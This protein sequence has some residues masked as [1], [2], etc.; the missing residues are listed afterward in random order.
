MFDGVKPSLFDWAP[1]CGV[2]I[3]DQSRSVRE[4]KCLDL[5]MGSN[6]LWLCAWLCVVTVVEWHWEDIGTAVG[7]HGEDNGWCRGPAAWGCQRG[8][9]LLGHN[10]YLPQLWP[11]SF[12]GAVENFVSLVI[13]YFELVFVDVRCAISI[14]EFTQAEYVVGESRDDVSC[15]C[16]EQWGAGDCQDCRPC[17][18]FGFPGGCLDSHFWCCGVNIEQWCSRHEVVVTC[19]SVYYCCGITV[20]CGWGG[21]ATGY[22]GSC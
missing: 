5:A 16:A 3:C 20:V 6:A 19:P 11:C 7:W 12:L 10:V 1:C 15:A 14:A 9:L 8:W 18:C 22:C 4:V 21:W 13:A 17:R 2:Q